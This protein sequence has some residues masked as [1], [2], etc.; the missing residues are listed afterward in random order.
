[1]RLSKQ[2]YKEILVKNESKL[3][4]L[5]CAYLRARRD[6]HLLHNQV[7]VDTFVKQYVLTDVFSYFRIKVLTNALEDTYQWILNE[8]REHFWSP[9][10][11]EMLNH[12][13]NKIC[14]IKEKENRIRQAGAEFVSFKKA[15][16]LIKNPL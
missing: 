15:I 6:R 9:T 10:P 5:L 13:E 4:L 12:L 8:R 16:D 3:L 14:S 11:D 1:M 2:V 7:A